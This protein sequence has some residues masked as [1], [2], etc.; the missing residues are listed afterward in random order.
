MEHFQQ[1]LSLWQSL[2]VPTCF[3]GLAVRIVQVAESGITRGIKV[4]V[5]PAN[6]K[7]SS[8]LIPVSSAMVAIAATAK[9]H[10]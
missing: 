8:G 7:N 4:D 2:V 3:G 6:A 5:L 1:A 10:P 9:G